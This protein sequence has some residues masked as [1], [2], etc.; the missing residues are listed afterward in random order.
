MKRSKNGSHHG[1]KDIGAGHLLIR[2]PPSEAFFDLQKQAEEAAAR[3]EE[4][5][6]TYQLLIQE[7]K[8][9]YTVN[10]KAFRDIKHIR[11][12]LIGSRTLD[13]L[14][15]NLVHEIKRLDV[16]HV[17]VAILEDV[18]GYADNSEDGLFNTL[19]PSLSVIKET[20]LN[21]GLQSVPSGP[22]AYIGAKC[23]C[24]M[25]TLFASDV[26]SCVIA[27][28]MIRDR[29][30]GSLNLG[31]RSPERFAADLSPDLLED[32]AATLGLCID[33]VISHERNERLAVTDPL[34]GVY[35]RRYFFEH[36]AYNF[37][38]AKRHKDPLSCIYFD[39][40]KFKTINDTFG[41]EAGDL[42]LQKLTRSIKGRIRRTDIL[43]RLGGDE[44]VLLLPRI[45]HK[46]AL[47]LAGA[48]RKVVTQISF[49]EN[50]LPDLKL[51]TALGVSS[52]QSEDDTLEDLVHRADLAMFEN[53]GPSERK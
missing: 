30:V 5:R 26:Q 14:I 36:A 4:L 20:D 27:P 51:S 17:S 35:N 29:V 19:G 33:S 40:N 34:T 45:S 3:L 38:L 25:P 18:V 46:E 32:L 16:N 1:P 7:A 42:A 31:S 44:F 21:K 15:K 10:E 39:L 53:K 52:Y 2:H 11:H 47:R 6:S 50:G 9:V 43:A 23:E 37:E 49:E 48:L 12:V 22:E 28:L 41:H 8:K 13:D 24:R